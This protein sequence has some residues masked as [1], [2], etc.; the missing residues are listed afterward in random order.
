MKRAGLTQI[1]TRELAGR[2]MAGETVLLVCPNWPRVRAIQKLI[3][4]EL[5]VYGLGSS[6]ICAMMNKQ[7]KIRVVGETK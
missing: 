5:E 1:F 2:I 3:I 6:E 7:T 4:R